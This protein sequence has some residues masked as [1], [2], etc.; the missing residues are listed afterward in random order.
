M[1][2]IQITANQKRKCSEMSIET[3]NDYEVPFCDFVSKETTTLPSQR[4]AVVSSPP[5]RPNDVSVALPLFDES[6]MT[7]DCFASPKT[8][9]SL[10]TWSE[11]DKRIAHNLKRMRIYSKEDLAE[12]RKYGVSTKL[13]L[14]LNPWKITK[15]LMESDLGHLSRLLIA[16]DAVKKHILPFMQDDDICKIESSR[17]M[18]V[19]VWDSDTKTSH[20]LVF[21]KW[22]TSNSY[23]FVGGWIKQFVKRRMLRLGDKIG[24][25][26]DSDNSKF[27][28]SVLEH[29]FS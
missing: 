20:G 5:T 19:T 18:T 3:T 10:K 24:F 8:E 1:E 11:L 27:N 17:G 21:K 26:W 4:P 14:C 28:F 13:T 16:T 23:V 22:S 29:K 2:A 12:E 9:G 6:W 15:T 25:Y 7:F